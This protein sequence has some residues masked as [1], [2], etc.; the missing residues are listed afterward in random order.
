VRVQPATPQLREPASRDGAANVLT[1][2]ICNG[3][4]GPATAYTQYLE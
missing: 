4:H 2:A 1:S 3:A